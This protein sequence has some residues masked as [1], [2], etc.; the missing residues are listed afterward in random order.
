MRRILVTTAATVLFIGLGSGS[1]FAGMDGPTVK[2]DGSS[3]KFFNVG[4][5]FEICD[6]D[7][8]GDAVYVSFYYAGSG[9]SVRLNNPNGAGTCLTRSYNIPEGRRVYYKS[10]QDDAFADTCSAY[11][12]GVA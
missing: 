4:D 8:D 6:T 12:T 5:K 3:A 1:A 10:C 9:G 7:S 2:T 11:V